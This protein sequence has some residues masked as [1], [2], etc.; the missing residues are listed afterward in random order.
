LL[1][2]R[3]D[4]VSARELH[5]LLVAETL[6][7]GLT[8]VYRA[9]R[10][11]EADGGVDVVRDEAGGRLY[12]RRP[13]DGHRHYLICRCCG[14]SRPVESEV[15]EEWADRIAAD[16]GFAAVQ[17]TVELTGLC[18]DCDT[19]TDERGEGSSCRWEPDHRGSRGRA[20]SCAS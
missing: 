8:T 20:R 15:V 9:L 7:I 18:A 17:H 14:R 4:F 19:T 16:T 12:R 2:G 6:P 5:A 1:A 3:Q 11:M 13:A 10:E